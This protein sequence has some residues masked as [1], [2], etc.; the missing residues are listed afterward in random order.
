M[1]SIS[2]RPTSVF[3]KR[4]DFERIN[5]DQSRR[6]A[7]TTAELLEVLKRVE[8]RTIAF[9]IDELARKNLKTGINRYTMPL[10]PKYREVIRR[11]I[12]MAYRRGVADVAGEFGF[13]PPRLKVSDLSR[14]R[15]R[16]DALADD[17]RSKLESEL[18]RAWAQ[19]VEGNI[20]KA[21]IIYVT[22]QVFADFTGWRQPTY[23]TKVR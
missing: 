2:R 14:V 15:A 16:A 10:F 20:V 17:H 3:E 12:T 18:R 19:A 1:P 22:R 8:S 4:I 7:A 5:R 23:P 11:R 13:K 9:A 6:S 21:Q